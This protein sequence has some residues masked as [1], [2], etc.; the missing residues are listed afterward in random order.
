MLIYKNFFILLI[1]IVY[2]G[3]RFLKLNFELFFY[4]VNFVD[5][6]IEEFDMEISW[7]M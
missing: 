5:I 3:Y 1:N 6:L 4:L 7:V 2:L